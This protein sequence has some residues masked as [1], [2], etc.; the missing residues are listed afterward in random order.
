MHRQ[1]RGGTA[2]LPTDTPALSS[3]LP[4]RGSGRPPQPALRPAG[5][6]FAS[7]CGSSRPGREPSRHQANPRLVAA[8]PAARHLHRPS[9]DDA[10]HQSAVRAG[11]R[12]AGSCPG[13]CA[14]PA[15][16]ARNDARGP[17]ARPVG[18]NPRVFALDSLLQAGRWLLMHRQTS[19]AREC[20][21]DT[22]QDHRG[23]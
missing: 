19:L 18:A 11:R 21:A 17:N 9:A 16:R 23:S 13:A 2:P 10:C 12:R 15:L 3:L 4:G 8:T 20:T 1:S 5:P 22:H 6:H 7:S 14:R